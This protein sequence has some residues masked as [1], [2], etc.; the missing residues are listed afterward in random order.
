[1]QIR[2]L[3]LIQF[4]PEDLDSRDR[5]AFVPHG[6]QS[7]ALKLSVRDWQSLDDRLIAYFALGVI[8]V[9]VYPGKGDTKVFV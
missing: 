1:M 7:L 4:V 5:Y 3:S 8:P 6:Y 2:G 9:V